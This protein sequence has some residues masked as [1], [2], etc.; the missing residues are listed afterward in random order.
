[1]DSNT[2]AALRAVCVAGVIGGA[3][4]AAFAHGN[5]TG[6]V[7]VRM[8]GM[9]QMAR[10]IKQVTEA[11]ESGTASP[12]IIQESAK[13]IGQHAGETLVS[14]FP[15]GSINGP[16]EASPAIWENWSEFVALANRLGALSSELAR[17]SISP[18]PDRDG[19]T[20]ASQPA[21][22]SLGSIWASLDERVLLGLS[23][24]PIPQTNSTAPTPEPPSLTATLNA[25][26]GTCAQCHE[27][28]RRANQ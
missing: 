12:T 27:A 8:H 22:K 23:P 28:F 26:T 14:L 19:I 17:A 4:G 11:V 9:M 24:T 2:F 7:A 1:M 20:A 5:A 6:I 3:V 18:V 16:S 15:E 25:I 21:P 10:S 13:I